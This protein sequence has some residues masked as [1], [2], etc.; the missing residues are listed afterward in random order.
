MARTTYNTIGGFRPLP[1]MED[2]DLIRR[3]PS[4]R[5]HVLPVR[6]VTSAAR[7]HRDG[8]WRRP[9]RNLACQMLW[10]LG[11]SAETVERLYR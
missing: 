8:Y 9:L 4:G 2:V 3:V 11:V 5:L 6:A 7:Y 1:I 10:R